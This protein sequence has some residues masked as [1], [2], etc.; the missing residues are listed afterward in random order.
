VLLP[1]E[2]AVAIAEQERQ[3]AEQERQRAEQESQRAE[4]ESQRAEQERQRADRLAAQL[5]TM[6]INPDA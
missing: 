1:E 6:G 2:T 4:Q 3:R 5:R